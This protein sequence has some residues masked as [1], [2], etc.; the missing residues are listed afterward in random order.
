MKQ[1][2]KRQLKIH[3]KSFARSTR[4]NVVFPEIRLCGKWLK[5]I[6]FECGGFVTIRH[7]KNIIIITVNKEIET[8]INK[9]KK[10]SK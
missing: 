10:A 3:R 6:G 9:T 8:N 4:K 7:E 1:L 2:E 5:D